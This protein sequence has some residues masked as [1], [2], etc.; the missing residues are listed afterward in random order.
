MPI[1]LNE[2]K[3]IATTQKIVFKGLHI[4]RD[5]ADKLNA[6][7]TFE[8]LD[9]N[10][11]QV[12]HEFLNYSG[13]EFNQFWNDFNSGTFLYQNLA[14]KKSLNPLENNSMEDDFV[15]EEQEQQQ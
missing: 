4:N 14:I 10:G 2:P 9:E 3:I 12:S 13:E 15:N 8:I 1:E 5:S 6:T 11:K 7:V